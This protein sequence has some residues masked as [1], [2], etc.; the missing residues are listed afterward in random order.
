MSDVCVSDVCVSD[1][2]VSDVCVSDVWES[3]ECECERAMNVCVYVMRVWVCVLYLI[4]QTYQWMN[5]SVWKFL[6]VYLCM[7]EN[8]YT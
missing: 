2:C 5:E 8:V 7:Y 4:Y 1:V 6:Y 3:D